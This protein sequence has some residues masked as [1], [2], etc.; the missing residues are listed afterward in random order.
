MSNHTDEDPME[1]DSCTSTSDEANLQL[2]RELQQSAGNTRAATELSQQTV[3]V[4]ISPAYVNGWD[5]TDAFR[6]L[7]QNWKDAIL[8]RFQLKRL[9]FRPFLEDKKDHFSIIVPTSS[10]E[11]G[12]SRALGFIK[13]E[14]KTGQVT[15]TNACMQLPVESL[16]M[17]FTSKNDLDQLAGSHGEGLK[18]AALVLSR[19][20]YRVSVAASQCKWQFGLHGKYQSLRCVTTPS[21]KMSPA[22]QREPADDMANLRFRVERD[23]TVLIGAGRAKQSPV[24]SPETFFK[25]LQVT[26]DIRGLSYPSSIVETPHGDLVLDLQFHGRLFLH[27][28][29]LPVANSGFKPLKFGYNLTRGKFSRDRQELVASCGV[30]QQVLQIWQCALRMHEQT[31]LPIYVNLLQNFPHVGDVDHADILLEPFLK[32]RIW[33]HLLGV[34]GRKRFFYCETSSVQSVGMIRETTGKTPT[35]LPK[36]LWNL[37]RSGSGIRTIEEEQV[38]LF[39]DAEICALPESTFAKT[40]AWALKACLALLKTTSHIKVFYVKGLTRRLDVLYNAEQGALKI[41]HR[42]LDFDATHHDASCR[43]WFPAAINEKHAPFFCS[44]IVEEILCLSISSMFKPSPTLRMTEMRY[45]RHISRLLRV[46]PH[47]IKLTPHS[48]GLLVTWEDNEAESFRKLGGG[49]LYRVVLHAEECFI[50]RSELLYLKIV[51]SGMEFASCGCRQQIV[52]QARRW[53]VFAALDHST[54]YYAMIS[55]NE[56]LAI[57]GL[58]SGLVSPRDKSMGGPGHIACNL[59]RSP[60]VDRQHEHKTLE[61]QTNLRPYQ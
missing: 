52:V 16:V 3:T 35:R 54:R 20:G 14:K 41:H 1:Q 46:M 7:Y 39:K 40:T 51:P 44:H 13:Y 30:A 17:G 24:V 29:L 34:A 2:D 8:E 48:G 45:M 42:W 53:C 57:Y 27:G 49:P 32:T 50:D 60:F 37:L 19:K 22:I 47:S 58:P 6:E 10:D 55:L 21:R 15:L 31:L 61:L 18:L 12:N 26:L 23:I 25:W 5:T 38:E 4:G 59:E 11:N 33:K 36:A 9:D 56:R 28:I 43:K